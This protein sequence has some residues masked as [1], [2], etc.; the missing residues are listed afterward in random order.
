M[1]THAHFVHLANIHV[2]ANLPQTFII[3]ITIVI[4]TIIIIIV[5]IITIVTTVPVWN[6]ESCSETKIKAV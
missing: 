2:S 1:E 4:I 5:I 6:P 3:I